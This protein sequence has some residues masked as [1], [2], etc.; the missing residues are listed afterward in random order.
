MASLL[1]TKEAA[2]KLSVSE[3]RVLA[4]ITLGRL[5]AQKVGRDWIIDESSLDL[6]AERKPGRPKK[7]AEENKAQTSSAKKSAAKKAKTKK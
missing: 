2:E 7:E 1:S 5:P 3:R 4:L 6:V